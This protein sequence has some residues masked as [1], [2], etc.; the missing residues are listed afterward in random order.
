VPKRCHLRLD[1]TYPYSVF[2]PTLAKQHLRIFSVFTRVKIDPS[3][4]RHKACGASA[5]S[6]IE[7]IINSLRRA[8][9]SL[10]ISKPDFRSV[11]SPSRRLVILQKEQPLAGMQKWSPAETGAEAR[12]HRIPSRFEWIP[13]KASARCCLHFPIVKFS[14]VYGIWWENPTDYTPCLVHY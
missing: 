3:P 2:H 6:V 9:R 11:S 13:R 7:A 5:A 12:P 8:K 14:P 1:A 10:K 4:T